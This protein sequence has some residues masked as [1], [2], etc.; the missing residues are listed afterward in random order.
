MK[1]SILHLLIAFVFGS[2]VYAQ[3]ATETLDIG[4]FAAPIR[5]DGQLFQN[6]TYSLGGLEWPKTA[7]PADKRYTTYSGQIWMAGHDQQGTLRVAANEYGQ[8]GECYFPGRSG[9]SSPSWNNL[10]KISKSEIDQFRADFANGTVNFTN[11]P[12][13]QSW[14]AYGT[15]TLGVVKPYAPYVN[16]DNNPADYNPS[17]GDY[18]DVPGDQAIF[19]GFTD[20]PTG[21]APRFVN[22]LGVDVLGMADRS[23]LPADAADWAWPIPTTALIS[24]MSFSCAMTS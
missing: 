21:Q 10:W 24:K 22:N 4:N 16:V 2:T 23:R 9:F 7:V 15:T 19:F 3:Q 20:A 13:I 1:K 5:S 6:S 18:P 11:Y 12:I 8:T 14:P 17:A